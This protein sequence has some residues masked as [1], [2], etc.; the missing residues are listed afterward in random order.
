MFTIFQ[1]PCFVDIISINNINKDYAINFKNDFNKILIKIINKKDNFHGGG[2]FCNV[3][4]RQNS[5]T[6]IFLAIKKK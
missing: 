1:E 3:F 2:R 5:D 4:I 6:K